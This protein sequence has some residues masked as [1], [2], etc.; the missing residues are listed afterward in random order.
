MFSH[1]P[2][3]TQS[4]AP[5]YSLNDHHRRQPLRPHVPYDTLSSPSSSLLSTVHQPGGSLCIRDDIRPDSRDQ[6][7]LGFDHNRLHHAQAYDPNAH[8]RPPHDNDAFYPPQHHTD[9]YLPPSTVSPMPPTTVASPSPPMV[10]Y[11]ERDPTDASVEV[12]T[13]EAYADTLQSRSVP[14][15]QQTVL[16]NRF[17]ASDPLR[18]SISLPPVPSSTLDTYG[19]RSEPVAFS[20]PS[21]DLR[22]HLY[23]FYRSIISPPNLPVPLHLDSRHLTSPSPTLFS[24]RYTYKPSLSDFPAGDGG[25]DHLASRIHYP[26]R[27]KLFSFDTIPPHHVLTKD[28]RSRPGGS[29]SSHSD[30]DLISRRA[31]KT[32]PRFS[33]DWFVAKTGATP[34]EAHQAGLTGDTLD[35]PD[36]GDLSLGDDGMSESGLKAKVKKDRIRRLEREFGEKVEK[37]QRTLDAGRTREG[38]NRTH[39]ERLQVGELTYRGNLIVHGPKK[40]L[41]LRWLQGTLIVLA[42][43]LEVYLLFVSCP[44]GLVILAFHFRHLADACH[45]CTLLVHLP[46][47]YRAFKVSQAGRRTPPIVRLPNLP[48][49]R[50][51]LDDYPRLF[52]LCPHSTAMLLTYTETT[53]DV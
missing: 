18:P 19:L 2:S 40:R 44:N 17:Y 43:S 16:D 39:E 1:A 52:R 30:D 35:E 37:N 28:S 48:H 12:L 34:R 3:T 21:S 11:H 36:H 38:G 45:D 20:L 46:L 15:P 4:P 51:H 23:P 42:V 6:P 10:A 5:D 24:P 50:P 29:F 27:P 7:H 47:L 26:L 32:F 9:P 49:L 53:F 25:G 8:Q 41:A 13:L 33:R 31:L 14:L 22:P